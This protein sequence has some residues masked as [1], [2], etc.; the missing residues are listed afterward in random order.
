[1]KKATTFLLSIFSLATCFGQVIKTYSGTYANGDAT[2]QYYENSDYERIFNGKFQYKKVKDN[3]N[4]AG[5]HVPSLTEINGLFKNNLKTGFWTGKENI[6][7]YVPSNG[8][9]K[10]MQTIN[11][12]F[13][14]GL[15]D[16]QWT[17][18]L[19]VKLNKKES[20]TSSIFNFKKNI[21]TGQIDF[22]EMKGNF[23]DNGNFANSWFIK[24]KNIEYIATF[25]NNTFSKLIIRNISDGEIIFRYDN[26][27]L[28]ESFKKSDSTTLTIGSKQYSIA[29]CDKL[30]N[31]Y[32][33][34]TPQNEQD[35]FFL[36]FYNIVFENLKD[37]DKILNCIEL[38]STNFQVPI[39]KVIIELGR[40]IFEEQ[41]N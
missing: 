39:P 17:Y 30:E 38:G 37:F 4:L 19:N 26:K 7:T 25:D 32:D 36:K 23:D 41:N 29:D 31:I 2:Y 9:L 15:K 10:I 40:Q 13:I 16:G 33:E 24:H 22:R 35:H 21:L 8:D 20:N 27:L 11:G 18:K 6:T 5:T 12:Q 34:N 3:L 28:A 1:M 14:N